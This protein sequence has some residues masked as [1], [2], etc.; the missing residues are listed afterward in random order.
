MNSIYNLASG[1]WA[2]SLAAACVPVVPQPAVQL[3]SECHFAFG[4]PRVRRL[5]GA[6]VE[7][8][9]I[10]QQAGLQGTKR[11]AVGRTRRDP[12]AKGW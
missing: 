4:S 12:N 5:L 6:L 11:R 8:H 9:H 7:R 10:G 1:R 3:L 2:P